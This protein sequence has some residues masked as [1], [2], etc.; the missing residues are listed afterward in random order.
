MSETT[1]TTFKYDKSDNIKLES[2]PPAL[3]A[4][5]EKQIEKFQR[6]VAAE[7][8]KLALDP[9][10]DLYVLPATEA[11]NIIGEICDLLLESEQTGDDIW[12]GTWMRT[13]EFAAEQKNGYDMILKTANARYLLNEIITTTLDTL[14]E[15][16]LGGLQ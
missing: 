6:F 9:Y 2:L 1:D 12:P 11:R 7:I 15:Q 16:P 3:K 13:R 14:T 8:L 10:E 5:C 4:H